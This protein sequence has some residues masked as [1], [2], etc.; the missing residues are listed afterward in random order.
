[1]KQ[2]SSL[3]LTALTFGMRQIAQLAAAVLTVMVIAL[4]LSLLS[5]CGGNN[6]PLRKQVSAYESKVV[7][8]I[9]ELENESNILKARID[10]AGRELRVEWFQQIDEIEVRKSKL[11]RKLED[12]K[13]ASA[14]NIDPIKIDI[15]RLIQE[16]QVATEDFA[17]TQNP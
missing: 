5:G 14:E 8:K 16:L 17:L 10:Y 1:M 11:N 6:Q 13:S 7:S 9:A 4:I 2:V 15:D 3:L 12:L